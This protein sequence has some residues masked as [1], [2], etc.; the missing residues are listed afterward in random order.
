MKRIIILFV[1]LYTCLTNSQTTF[2]K[3]IYFEFDKA[4]IQLKS[5]N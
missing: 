5:Q 4:Q 2:E 1:F 3:K